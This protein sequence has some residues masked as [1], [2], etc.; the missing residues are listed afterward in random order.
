MTQSQN[1]NT[2]RLEEVFRKL[3]A[4]SWVDPAFKS[5]LVN[6]PFAVFKEHGVEL[7]P[8]KTVKIWENSPDTVHFVI[9]S[10]PREAGE[11]SQE[12]LEVVAGG[13]GYNESGLVSTGGH[14]TAKTTST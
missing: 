12:E 7:D 6:E 2:T 14:A 13:T 3:I 5:R 11:L 9:P 10:P 1:D 4:R 8:R